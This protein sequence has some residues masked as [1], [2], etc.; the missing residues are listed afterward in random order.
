MTSSKTTAAPSKA[1]EI[2]T[3]KEEAR[4]MLEKMQ[5]IEKRIARLQ[6]ES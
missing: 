5:E 3:L 2:R 6:G 4:E 1:E